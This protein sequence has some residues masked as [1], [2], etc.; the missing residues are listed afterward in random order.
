[1]FVTEIKSNLRFNKI[2]QYE[3]LEI[4]YALEMLTGNSEN[5][6]HV[7]QLPFETVNSDH[8]TKTK[9]QRQ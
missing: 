7:F 5:Q 3:S 9:E 4:Y 1:M 6:K 2:H 8:G